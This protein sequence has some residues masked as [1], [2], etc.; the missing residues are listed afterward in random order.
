MTGPLPALVYVNVACELYPEIAPKI[1]EGVA[2]FYDDPST[3]CGEYL[4][5]KGILTDEQNRLVL[6]AQKAQRSLL[7]AADKEELQQLQSEVHLRTMA[8]I[9]ELGMLLKRMKS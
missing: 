6:L 7:D 4:V 2:E 5:Q 3:R 1:R 9:E 8:S